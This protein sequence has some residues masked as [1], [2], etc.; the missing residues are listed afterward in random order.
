MTYRCIAV[1]RV[2][3]I[4]DDIPGL[5]KRN[6]KENISQVGLF[7]LFLECLTSEHATDQFVNE[8]VHRLSGLDQQDDPP[9]FLQLGHH[10]L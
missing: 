1:L 3:A 6:L 10:V 9:G 4:D 8:V 5:Q 7:F 2:A